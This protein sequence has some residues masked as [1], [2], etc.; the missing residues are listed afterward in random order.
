MTTHQ[1]RCTFPKGRDLRKDLPPDPLV[2]K[3]NGN[4]YKVFYEQ[5]TGIISIRCAR[6]IR[7]LLTT[8]NG[9]DIKEFQK[10]GREGTYQLK[11][12]EVDKDGNVKPIDDGSVISTSV[13]S[14]SGNN[15]DNISSE[16]DERT[17][18]NE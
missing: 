9:E 6:D 18:D 12:G 14:D 16:T 3:C 7:H 4:T 1:I 10:T 8:L 17:E 11:M 2:P 15:P 5:E 13:N